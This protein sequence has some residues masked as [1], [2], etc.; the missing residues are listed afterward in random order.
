MHETRKQERHCS[1][2]YI[3]PQMGYQEGTKTTERGKTYIQRKGQE[4]VREERKVNKKIGTTARASMQK[5][6]PKGKKAEAKGQRQKK[7]PKAQ[8]QKAKKQRQKAKGKKAKAKGQKAKKQR[9]KAKSKKPQGK[10][11]KAT[12]PEAKHQ[13]AKSHPGKPA[14]ER[15]PRAEQKKRP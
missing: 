2:T 3:Q 7:R 15:Q 1:P 14:Q 6:R 10:A 11:K 12:R 13:K 5:N 4:R 9:H 8:G